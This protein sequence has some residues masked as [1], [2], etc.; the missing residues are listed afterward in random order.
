MQKPLK[1]NV[2]YRCT[3]IVWMTIKFIIQIYLFH[4]RHRIWDDRTW[5]KWN[6][7]LSKIAKEYRIK[8]VKLGGVLIKV[9]QFLSTRADLMPDVFIKELTGLV[10]RVPPVSFSYAKHVMEQE[11]GGSI[12]DHFSEILEKPIASASIGQVY[13]GRLLDGTLVAIKIRRRHVKETFH[14]DFKALKIVF[15]LMRVF[16]RLGK[17]T[18]LHTLYREL[19]F[20][21]ERELHFR[22]ELDFAKY[23]KERYEGF[24]SIHI[25]DY[26]DELC[27]DKI[28]VMEWVKGAK[29][30]DVDFMHEHEINIRETAKTLFDFYFD[31]FFNPG[32][33]HADPHAGNILIQEDGTIVII[34]F[35]MIGEIRKQDTQLFK[36][37][38][39]GIIVDDYDKILTALDEMKFL[40][41]N[42]D[43]NSLIKMF[44]QTIEMYEN[45]SFNNMDNQV[46]EQIKDD[47][48]IFI[49]EQPIQLSADYAY[50]GRAVSIV[51]GI[52]FGIYPQIDLGKWAKPLIKEWFGGKTFIESVYKEIAKDALKPVISFPKAMLDFLERGE[53]DRKWQ[54]KKQYNRLLHQF[55]LLLEVISFI[56]VAGSGL[57]GI[58]AYQMRMSFLLIGCVIVL[59]IFFFILNLLFL[60]HYQMIQSNK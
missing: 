14:M 15:W 57:T 24:P 43:R 20:V 60:R 21:M 6:E 13:Q 51:L 25:P 4:V 27:T 17:K 23:F 7:L 46:M 29:I 11:W 37:L 41:P 50:L 19:I 55:Y 9:G 8:A 16:T 54:K 18:D 35:G 59:V 34:D 28:L 42:A 31:Q 52:L 40:L 32:Y 5:Q 10:D 44:K 33:F 1:Y 30:V 53:K 56:M 36:R 3:V 39:Q 38:I 58:Y 47:I 48:R 45:G 49:R 26:Y 12:D 22:Q 2:I